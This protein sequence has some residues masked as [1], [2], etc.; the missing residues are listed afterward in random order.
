MS[1]ADVISTFLPPPS[2]CP[3]FE[4]SD[5]FLRKHYPYADIL[6]SIQHYIIQNSTTKQPKFYVDQIPLLNHLFLRLIN[7]DSSTNPPLPRRSRVLRSRTV[8]PSAATP[9]TIT[10]STVT[11]PP[12]TATTQ[13]SDTKESVSSVL[14]A[15]D[16]H[17]HPRVPIW[18]SD[19][20]KRIEATYRRFSELN[21]LFQQLSKLETALSNAQARI[22]ELELQLTG[23]PSFEK[24]KKHTVDSYTHISENTPPTS[25]SPSYAS[26]ASS[27]PHKYTANKKALACSFL[28]VSTSQGFQ[29]LYIHC[30]QK[31]PVSVMRAK[32]RS[33]GL[34]SSRIL[35]IH[36]PD[37]N[38]V[39]I[40]V[41]NDYSSTVKDTL[42]SSGICINTDFNPLSPTILRDHKYQL[43]PADEKLS[44]VIEIHQNRLQTVI[45]RTINPSTQRALPRA[46]LH[47][48]SQL[49]NPTA[50][51]STDISMDDV[52]SSF[53]PPT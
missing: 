3:N 23:V 42:T 34:Q 41:H 25:S 13:P 22:A 39:A 47:N 19:I 37:N 21:P 30:R 35:N 53:K 1:M 44:K 9:S 49:E 5:T 20:N 32:L 16:Y 38:V 28:P 26:I 24:K 6:I 50:L 31:D 43:L 17:S 14:Q 45:R 2:S 10:S 29:Y 7:V 18:L 46:S 15:V 48:V 12:I 36:Y 33:L 40:L 11:T 8:P 52:A 4:I 51:N 27:P